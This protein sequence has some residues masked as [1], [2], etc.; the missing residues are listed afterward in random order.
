MAPA[1][2]WIAVALE[3]TALLHLMNAHSQVAHASMQGQDH[4]ADRAGTSWMLCMVRPYRG[5][6]TPLVPIWMTPSAPLSQ[7]TH[8]RRRQLRPSSCSAASLGR[9]YLPVSQ[10]PATVP[11]PLPAWL[12][13]EGGA[14]WAWKEVRGQV[15]SLSWG[16][17]LLSGDA[18][19]CCCSGCCQPF[20]SA[21]LTAAVVGH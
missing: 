19:W 11:A 2:S 1:Q 5:M 8:F 17:A 20:Y 16:S 9:P 21:T 18:D 6:R 13:C 4:P 14:P 12:A 3:L 15:R 7:V 10:A